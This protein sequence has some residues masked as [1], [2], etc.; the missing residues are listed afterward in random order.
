ML[1]RNYYVLW[2]HSLKRSC[3][4]FIM[5]NVF[6]SCPKLINYNKRDLLIFSTYIYIVNV[7]LAFVSSK[8]SGFSFPWMLSTVE[9]FYSKNDIKPSWVSFVLYMYMMRRNDCCTLVVLGPYFETVMLARTHPRKTDQYWKTEIF[10][11]VTVYI[12]AINM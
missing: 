9:L 8:L 10:W 6:P 3:L 2:K 7:R 11:I 1:R 4:T 5:Y 12:R